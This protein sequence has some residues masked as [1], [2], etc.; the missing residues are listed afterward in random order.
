MPRAAARRPRPTR[1]VRARRAALAFGVAL[2]AC[3]GAQAQAPRPADPVVVFAAA[4]LAN[5]FE[6]IGRAWTARGGAPVR[7]S[8]AASSTLAR[9]IEQ[10]APAGIFA[11][12]DREWMDWLIERKL[13]DRSIARTLATNALVVVVPAGNPATLSLAAGTDVAAAF[14]PG[15][16][17]TGDPAHVPVGRYARQALE[18][19]GA[20]NALAPRLVRADNVRSA[21][22]FVERGEVGSGI[23]YATDAA[24]APRVRVA[25]TFPP[26]T[27]PRI[28]YPVARLTGRDD[29]ATRAFFDFLVGPEAL[30]VLRK[31]GFGDP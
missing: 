14:P 23:V 19:L 9:Q 12:A 1:L 21:L 25:G 3:A 27:H 28:V 7:F 5:A 15:R 16:I 8:F 22:A 29:E 24:V 26:G 4:S 18:K 13:A 11:S 10:G 31:H 20:W 6:E 2:A 30:A 17:A